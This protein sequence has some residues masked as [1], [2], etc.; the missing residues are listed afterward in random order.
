MNTCVIGI[1]SNV[2]ATRNIEKMMVLLNKKVTVRKVSSFIQ[3]KPIG[4]LD[5][6]DFING[7]VLIQTNMDLE[8]LKTELIKIEDRMGRDRKGPKFG[9]RC[10]DLDIVIWNNRVVD[11]DYHTRDF[12]R[13]SVKELLDES[14]LKHLS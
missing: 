9:P 10:I 14:Q 3:T 6:A 8:H 7:A 13:N 12:L 2:D 1:G 11:E 4:V 5:Q